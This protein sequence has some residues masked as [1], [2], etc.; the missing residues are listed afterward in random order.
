V[1]HRRL[2]EVEETGRNARTAV[3]IPEL[4]L[5]IAVEIEMVVAVD[6]SA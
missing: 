2:V 3:G 5:D 1:R 4:P 6:A